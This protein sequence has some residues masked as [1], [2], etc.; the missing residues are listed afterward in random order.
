MMKTHVFYLFQILVVELILYRPEKLTFSNARC[1][2]AL[3]NIY[4]WYR[5]YLVGML[6][7]LTFMEVAKFV[8]G[9]PRPH[10]LDTCAPKE[11]DTCITGE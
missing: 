9:E 2:S 5:E 10:F 1:K 4:V 7:T 11:A 6:F 3:R 8:V